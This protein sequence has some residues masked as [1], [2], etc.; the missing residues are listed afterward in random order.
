M[1]VVS[2]SV[3]NTI[4][5][6]RRFN[7]FTQREE[8]YEILEICEPRI[9]SSHGVHKFTAT[10]KNFFTVDDKFHRHN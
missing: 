10:T 5:N 1:E 6:I 4:H 3:L 9:R 8:I 7:S 2:I